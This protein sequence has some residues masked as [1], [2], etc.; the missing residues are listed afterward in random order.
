MK[1][2]VAVQIAGQRYVLRS[3]DGEEETVRELAAYV[4]ARMREIQRQSR[5]SDTQAV[6]T[7]A[8]L[9]IAEELFG[10]RKAAAELKRKIRE[11]GELLLQFLE[12]EAHL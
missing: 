2:Q 9:Q 5:T 12:R 4:D 1:R 3:D 10:E 6:A 11:K 8:A 7:L